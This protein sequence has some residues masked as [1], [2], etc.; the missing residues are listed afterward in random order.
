MTG[1]STAQGSI[2]AASER[3]PMKILFNLEEGKEDLGFDAKVIDQEVTGRD[4]DH[5]QSEIL[6]LKKLQNSDSKRPPLGGKKM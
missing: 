4:P 1:R 3:T 6:D 5:E 2:A